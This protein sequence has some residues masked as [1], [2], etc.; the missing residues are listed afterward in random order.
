MDIIIG[1]LLSFGLT[2]QEATLYLTLLENGGLTGYE[3]AKLTGISRSNTYS[4]LAG[5]TEKGAAYLMEENVNKYTAVPFREFAG[6]FVRRLQ[7]LEEEIIPLLPRRKTQSQGYI[8]IRGTTHI[9]DKLITMIQETEYRL[10]LSVPP[11]ILQEIKEHLQKLINEGR[12]VVI[13]T[14]VP[15]ALEGAVTYLTWKQ[16][17]QIRL[18]ADS[19]KVLTGRILPGEDSTCLYSLNRN[20]VDVFKDML[21]NEI[22]LIELGQKEESSS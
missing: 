4:A 7:T 9:M 22:R 12:R 8:T 20:L 6:N 2:R 17:C 16:D 13:L 11:D 10:Y 21:Q 1:K 18:I 15:C 3:A 14:S 19:T 5:L